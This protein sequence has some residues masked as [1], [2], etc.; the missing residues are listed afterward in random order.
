MIQSAW[1][2]LA[3]LG[4][5]QIFAFTFALLYIFFAAK[6]SIFCWA[7]GIASSG[8]WAFEA[9]W[10]YELFYDAFLNIFYVV[11]GGVGWWNWVHKKGT[12]NS[13]GIISLSRSDHF[14]II[15]GGGLLSLISGFIAWKF[16][17]ASLPFIDAPTTVFSIIA[18]FLLIKKELR[19]W[20][21]WIF[22][23]A[24]YVGIYFYKGAYLF[25]L[26]F[27]IYTVMALYG[28]LEWRKIRTKN[29]GV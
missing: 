3:D 2:T 8:L 11:M 27:I 19:N 18:T 21:Y 5:V 6:N 29:A 24:V 7:F 1:A 13:G 22:V 14:L 20:L 10:V 25:G 4:Y 15:L 9:W 12:S 17:S 16:S 26:L 23:D 28:W